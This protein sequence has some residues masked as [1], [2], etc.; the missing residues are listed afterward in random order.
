VL[1]AGI[2][3]SAVEGPCGNSRRSSEYLHSKKTSNT[4]CNETQRDHEPLADQYL[5]SSSD[6][7]IRPGVCQN[8]PSADENKTTVGLLMKYQSTK[9]HIYDSKLA[10]YC[11]HSSGEAMVR[12]MGLQRGRKLSLHFS[13][14]ALRRRRFLLSPDFVRIRK[15]FLHCVITRNIDMF[16]TGILFLRS[17]LLVLLSPSN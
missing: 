4:R 8:I 10:A 6:F 11:N 17:L 14:L 13:I 5:M 2:L 1:E 12:A 9:K 7:L 15:S 16:S 3:V